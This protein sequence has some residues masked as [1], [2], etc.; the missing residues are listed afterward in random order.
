M[1]LI[2]VCVGRAPKA[3]EQ[4]LCDAYLARARGLGPRLGFS[5]IELAVVETSRASTAEARAE[6]EAK[7]LAK[8]VPNGAVK[9]ALDEGG[10]P[11]SSETLA[12][13]LARLRDS[14]VR[15]VAFIVGGPDGIAPGL[16]KSAERRLSFGAPTWPHLLV[17][18]MLA[19]QIYRCL[20]VLAGHP[21]HRAARL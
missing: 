16:R 12:R 8:H 13:E 19:E 17:R 11:L 6:E 4:A 20:S 7:R 10:E 3:P 14:G 9:I 21:Y 18:A 1:R 15:D 2:A 5:T